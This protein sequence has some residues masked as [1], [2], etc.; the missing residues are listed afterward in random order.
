MSSKLLVLNIGNTHAQLA[1]WE[2]G[3]FQSSRVLP[4][5]GLGPERLP[6][7]LPVAAACVVPAVKKALAAARPD[8]FWV[9]ASI[10]L[11]FS[12]DGVDPSTLG[13]DRLANAA[14][15]LRLHPPP[16]M[17]VDC[18]TAITSEML[19]PGPRFLG[20][21]IAPGRKLSRL[22]LHQHTAQLPLVPFADE[23]PATLGANTVDAIRFGVDIGSLGLVKEIVAAGKELL[24]ADCPVLVTGGDKGF[25]LSRIPGLRRAPDDFTLRGVVSLWL[26]NHPGHGHEG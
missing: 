23:L 7:G 10:T 8:I 24:E 16:G 14:A 9:S 21:A 19:G 3:E 2:D 6:A 4:T 17:V 18:G 11:P 15:F 25:F 5:D 22:A 1:V 26:L 13:A 12:L 20:G